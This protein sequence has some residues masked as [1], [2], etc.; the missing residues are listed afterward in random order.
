MFNSLKGDKVLWGILALLAIFSFLP[1]FSAS[2]NLAYVVGKGTPWGYLF[3]HFVILGIGFVLM[4]SIHKIPYNYFKGISILMLPVVMLLL[5]YTASQGTVIDGANASRWIR[6]PIIG[7]SFQTSTLASV[8]AMIYT[9]RYFSKHK[10]K[11]ISFKSSLIELWLPIFIVVLLI[12]PSNLSTAAL[13]FLMVLIVSFV[14]G[15]PI[16]YLLTICGTGLVLVMLFFLLIKSFPGV[17]PNRVDTWMSRIENFSSGESADGNYQVERAKTAIVTG[18]IFG[19]GAGKSRMKNFL[20]QSS[21]DFIYAIIVEEFGLI[22]GIG[23]IILYLLLLFRIVVISYKATD[24]FGKLVVIG[25]GIPIIFQAFINMGV[26]LQVLPVTGQTLPMISSGGTSAWMTCIA[27]G[28]ILSV[29]AK[30]NLIEDQ[31]DDEDINE[32]NPIS[33]LSETL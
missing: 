18:K 7:L 22:G 28:I 10:D 4:F 3:K 26:A 15:Y 30:K 25:L 21:S 24:V 13:L 8:I 5:L 27:M 23:L 9:A 16:K 31:L 32:S 2:S 17:F 11:K 20:P 33:I 6:I 29:S 1:V 19:V 12:F 14:A